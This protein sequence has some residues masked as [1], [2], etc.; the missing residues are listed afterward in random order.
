MIQVPTR[1]SLMHLT[2]GN[3]LYSSWS[4][5][6]W[7]VLHAFA[8]PFNETVVPLHTPAFDAFQDEARAAGASGTVPL[9]R[10]P[11]AAA[12]AAPEDAPTL[13]IWETLAIIEHLAER[14]PD[15]AIWPADPAARAHARS[16]AN[17]MHA[18]FG[19]LR[20][21]C[22]M[23]FGKRFAARDR[24]AA[25]AADVARI[26]ALWRAARDR[27]GTPSNAGPFLYGAF[28]AADAMYAP[29]VARFDGYSVALSAT[30]QNYVDAVLAQ[31]S[32]VAWREAGLAESWVVDAD[33]VDEPAVVDYRAAR[34]DGATPT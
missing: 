29:V 21:A 33:E 1:G 2:I 27:F 7:L 17:E 19:A 34:A 28:T 15:H 10:D 26:E 18:G 22:P 14:F 6:P 30:A 11:D 13:L 9:L 3:K 31:P 12:K 32:V 20:A 8:I 5:R 25:V 4:M 24:G 16:I 23:N